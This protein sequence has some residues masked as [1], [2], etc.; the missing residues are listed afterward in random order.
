MVNAKMEIYQNAV[1]IRMPAFAAYTNKRVSY[2]S[3][4]SS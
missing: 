2:K 1:T 3:W 4:V